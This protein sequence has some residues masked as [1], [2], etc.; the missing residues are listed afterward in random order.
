MIGSEEV[1]Y[2]E[3]NLGGGGGGGIRLPIGFIFFKILFKFVV[4]F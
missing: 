1:N 3:N 4:V 2:T